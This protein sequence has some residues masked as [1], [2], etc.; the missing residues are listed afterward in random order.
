MEGKMKA[1]ARLE[2]EGERESYRGEG[3]SEKPYPTLIAQ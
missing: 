3:G 1:W 2:K